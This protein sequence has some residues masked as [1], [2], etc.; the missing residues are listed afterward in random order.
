MDLDVRRRL[1]SDAGVIAVDASDVH[2]D[3]ITDHDD[4]AG[5][6]C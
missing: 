4:F 3:V 2:F 1:N 6:P 5:L